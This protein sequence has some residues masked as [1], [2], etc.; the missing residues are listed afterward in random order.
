VT[1]VT[2]VPVPVPRRLPQSAAGRAAEV[3]AHWGEWVDAQECMH[4]DTLAAREAAR[5][6]ELRAWAALRSL[7]A[8]TS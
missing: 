4:A 6:D 8:V 7:G 1:A 5:V 3:T 2:P